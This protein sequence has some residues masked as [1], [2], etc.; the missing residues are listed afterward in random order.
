MPS[1]TSLTWCS[2]TASSHGVEWN[3]MARREEGAVERP[4]TPNWGWLA[5]N[6][7]ETA[8]KRSAFA[9]AGLMTPV[10]HRVPVAYAGIGDWSPLQN[11]QFHM[12]SFFFLLLVDWNFPMANDSMLKLPEGYPFLWNKQSCVSGSRA[13][14][15]GL[16][17]DFLWTYFI[18][19]MD[20]GSGSL[21]TCVFC[22]FCQWEETKSPAAA[23]VMEAAGVSLAGECQTAICGEALWSVFFAGHLPRN[24]SKNRK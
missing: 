12:L 14:S 4:V 21:N 8:V 3:V 16:H 13:R 20:G 22:S 6:S 24:K 7:S 1:I 10:Q 23:A 11:C 17:L 9:L 15:G 18:N 2:W 19:E 5:E